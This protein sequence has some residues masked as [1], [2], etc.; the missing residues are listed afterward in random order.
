MEDATIEKK[1][2]EKRSYLETEVAES[3]VSGSMFSFYP[4]P[5]SAVLTGDGGEGNAFVT[6]R[7]DHRS[8]LPHKKRR[9]LPE[10]EKKSLVGSTINL[11]RQRDGVEQQPSPF[12]GRTLSTKQSLVEEGGSRPTSELLSDL[13]STVYESSPPVA[14][15]R[16]CAAPPSALL[17]LRGTKS[18]S[19]TPKKKNVEAAWMHRLYPFDGPTIE[20]F[21]PLFNNVDVDRLVEDKLA[22]MRDK[23]LAQAVKSY[24]GELECGFVE[25]LLLPK[26]RRR[27]PHNAKPIVSY[28]VIYSKSH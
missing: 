17:E 26:V 7:I 24:Y 18:A 12:L 13:S 21:T 2:S 16:E 25:H 28:H 9:P 10:E 1:L 8:S 11:L 4:S 14:S 27:V 20:E 19:A 15:I 3:L 22:S 5:L 6:Q 23:G